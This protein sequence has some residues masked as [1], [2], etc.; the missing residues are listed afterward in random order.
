M[1]RQE[2]PGSSPY[3]PEVKSIDRRSFGWGVSAAVIG[4]LFLPSLGKSMRGFARKAMEETMDI[5]DRF[6][7]IFTQV[8]EEFEDIVAEANFNRLKDTVSKY[9][10][11]VGE[12]EPPS[13]E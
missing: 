5:T 12:K 4:L 10:E 2:Q 9:T 11:M 8:K 6:Q 7:G 13:N 3:D 1:I